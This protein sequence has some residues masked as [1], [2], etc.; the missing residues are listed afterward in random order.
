LALAAAL[1]LAGRPV[2]GIALAVVG[3]ALAA[4]FAA[5]AR[6]LFLRSGLPRLVTVQTAKL[7]DGLAR[8]GRAA[9]VAGAEL[10]ARAAHVRVSFSAWSTAV[11]WIARCRRA[12]RR[13]QH[14]RSKLIQALGEATYLGKPDLAAVLNAEAHT[15]AAL[16]TETKRLRGL[17]TSQARERIARHQGATPR[18]HTQPGMR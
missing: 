18:T 15:I 4:V 12:Q 16:I 13:F 9:I 14:T 3:L 7:R 2:F 11:I 10:R 8:S 1:L 17:T 5:E 6:Q